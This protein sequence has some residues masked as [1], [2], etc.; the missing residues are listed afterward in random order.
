MTSGVGVY[1]I[2]PSGGTAA[3][4]TIT[5][6]SGKLNIV[7]SANSATTQLTGFS[8]FSAGSDVGNGSVTLYNADKSEAMSPYGADFTGGVRT[9]SADFT[10]DGVAD[11]V[12]GT[13]P[14]R[15]TRVIVFDGS[16]QQ[17]L[18]TV[19][20]FEAS[21]TGGVYIAAGDLNGDGVADLVIADE[22]GGPRRLVY[23]TATGSDKSPTSSGSTTPTS[24]AGHEPV[25]EHRRRSTS[26]RFGHRGGIWRWAVRISADPRS[27]VRA[28]CQ[29]RTA[30]AGTVGSRSATS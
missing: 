17:Q 9:V 1:D 14:G 20:P 19:D 27:P 8:Q 6:V 4:Y 12:V 10:G 5:F 3:N 22:G 28:G 23:L 15:A 13:G 24:E 11:L 29:T 25:G 16:S 26:V 7:P 18:F 21:F 30:P 2:T